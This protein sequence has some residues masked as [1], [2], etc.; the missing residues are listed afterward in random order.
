MKALRGLAIFLAVA[1]LAVFVV[2]M[3]F[4]ID[5]F[6]AEKTAMIEGYE[7]PDEYEDT[8]Y[9]YYYNNLND[10]EKLAYRIVYAS[11]FASAEDG[12]P[13]QIVIPKLSNEELQEMYTAL[14]YDNPDLYFLGNKCSM[15]SIGSVNYFV[16]QYVMNMDDY[17]DSWAEVSDTVH[18]IVASVP[19]TALN[20]YDIEVYLHDYIVQNCEYE[21]SNSAMIYTMHGVLVDGKANCEGYSRTMQYLLRS[22]GIYNYLAIGDA[23]SEAGVYEGHMWNI[24]KV[25]GVTY[26][27]DVTWDDYSVSDSVDYPDNSVSHTFFNMS[28]KD[29]SDTHKV[30]DDSIWKDCTAESYSYFKNKGLYFSAYDSSAEHAMKNAVAESLDLGYNSVEFAF[31]DK[32]T[33]DNALRIMV[34]QGSMYNIITYANSRVSSDKRVNASSV[35]YALDENNLIMRF[36]FMK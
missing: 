13:D 2:L 12:F 30:N 32:A 27:L 33:F 14:S 34:D 31:S 21:E 22:L 36:F 9:R 15:T 11:F 20:E 35:Q 10:S 19:K 26:N 16:P 7:V 18:L 8:L 28:T 23:E 29:I 24:V 5:T 1:F 4:P 17:H 6:V 25:D 3:F